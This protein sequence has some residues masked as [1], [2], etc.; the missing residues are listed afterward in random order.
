M[1]DA[2]QITQACNL[3]VK[4][5]NEI[6]ALLDEI[7]TRLKERIS[8]ERDLEFKIGQE[9]EEENDWNY[10]D[11]EWVCQNY[12]D[13]IPIQ[14][15]GKGKWRRKKWLGCQVSLYGAGTEFADPAEPLLHVFFLEEP[16]SFK[17]QRWIFPGWRTETGAPEIQEGRIAAWENHDEASWERRTW[18]YTLKLLRIRSVQDVESLVVRP[19]IMLMNGKRASEALTEDLLSTGTLV[20]WKQEGLE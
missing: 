15:L 10:D 4:T 8:K 2:T 9:S 6:A 11:E 7:S 20:P 12:T 5:G 14:S 13:A 19:S 1:I 3:I 16:L 17:D 18:I